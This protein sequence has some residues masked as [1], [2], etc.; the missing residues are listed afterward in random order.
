VLKVLGRP[1]RT[2]E[3]PGRLVLLLEIG[4]P[5]Q[6]GVQVVGVVPAGKEAQV[7][8]E[9]LTKRG[10][11]KS[12]EVARYLAARFYRRDLVQGGW[13]TDIAVARSASLRDA[14]ETMWQFA[15]HFIRIE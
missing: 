4:G 15:W 2:D 7:I 5:K 3:T 8:Y 11:R 12:D 10:L 14:R 6:S 9:T 1:T 13:T